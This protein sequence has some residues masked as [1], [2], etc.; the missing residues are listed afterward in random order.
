MKNNKAKYIITLVLVIL[1]T[2]GCGSN[3]YIKDKKGKIVTTK[4][5]G[6]SLQKDIY[7]KP[8][9]NTE[10]INY[11]LNMKINLLIN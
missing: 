4:E 6:Q 11:I 2:S 3:N 1:L 8:S 9:E 5:T 10:A 7:C